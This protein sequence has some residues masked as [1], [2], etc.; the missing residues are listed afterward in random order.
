MNNRPANYPNKLY[1]DFYV[2]SQNLAFLTYINLFT[3]IYCAVLIPQTTDIVNGYGA[4]PLVA[5]TTPKNT[6]T[7]TTSNSQDWSDYTTNTNPLISSTTTMNSFAAG[8]SLVSNPTTS[9][10]LIFSLKAPYS[11]VTYAN[12][13]AATPIADNWGFLIMMNPLINFPTGS[14]AVLTE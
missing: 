3:D 6:L 1:N 2:I 5:T 8:A 9:Q 14:T 7:I 13:A 12:A 11:T 4:I 10:S